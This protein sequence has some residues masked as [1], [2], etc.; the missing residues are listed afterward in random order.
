MLYTK[1]IDIGIIGNALLGE[2]CTQIS[3]VGSDGKGKL[4]QGEVMLKIELCHI[5]DRI[6]CD[7][8]APDLNMSR[9]LN[10]RKLP[11]STDATAAETI[12]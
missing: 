3:T 12:T 10:I 9:R 4:L 2:I 5:G 6:I 8:A 7:M 1:T 11:D